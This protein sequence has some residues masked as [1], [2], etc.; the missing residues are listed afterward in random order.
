MLTNNPLFEGSSN[1]N[2]LMKIIR[3]LG[4]PTDDDF[5]GMKVEKSD[6]QIVNVEAYGI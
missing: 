1:M 2:Q 5:R 4:S 3:I 6:V